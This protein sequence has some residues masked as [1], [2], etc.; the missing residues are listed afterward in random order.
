MPEVTVYCGGGGTGKTRHAQEWCRRHAGKR[1]WVSE[2]SDGAGRRA[3][4]FSMRLWL[5]RARH[6]DHVCVTTLDVGI[7]AAFRTLPTASIIML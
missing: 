1:H 2:W 7:S 3:K 6:Y 4:R 5:K